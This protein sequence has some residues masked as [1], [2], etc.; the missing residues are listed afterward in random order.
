[1]LYTCLGMGHLLAPHH[2]FEKKNLWTRSVLGTHRPKPSQKKTM[3]EG[4]SGKSTQKEKQ[5]WKCRKQPKEEA[6]KQTS[7]AQQE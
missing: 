5:K 4:R 3:R 2:L 6:R 1:M 7:G